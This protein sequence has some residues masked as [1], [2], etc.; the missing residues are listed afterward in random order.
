M[1]PN[2]GT[3]LA[4]LLT[5][6]RVAVETWG[7]LWEEDVLYAYNTNTVTMIAQC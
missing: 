6:A 3:M 2:N 4:T 7:Q 1:H 5:A